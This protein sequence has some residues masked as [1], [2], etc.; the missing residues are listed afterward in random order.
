MPHVF[1]NGYVV[2]VPVVTPNVFTAQDASGDSFSPFAVTTHAPDR[3]SANVIRTRLDGSVSVLVRGD[4]PR[5]GTFEMVF[6]ENDAA[7]LA[8][9]ILTRPTRFRYENALRPD[10]SMTFARDGRLTTTYDASTRLWTFTVGFQ[11]TPA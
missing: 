5:A 11:E 1:Q 10:L 6:N 8:V 2:W 3:E 9:S 4:K 7:A